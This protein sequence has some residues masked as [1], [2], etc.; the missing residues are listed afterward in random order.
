MRLELKFSV[1]C[2]IVVAGSCVAPSASVAQRSAFTRMPRSFALT[3]L[4]GV[5]PKLVARTKVRAISGSEAMARVA[6]AHARAANPRYWDRLR[7][8]KSKNTYGAMTAQPG[9][10]FGYGNFQIAITQG[11]KG[12]Q[13]LAIFPVDWM[14]P[15][16]SGKV[17][18]S[19]GLHATS[20]FMER[21]R[22]MAVVTKYGDHTGATLTRFRRLSD[23]RVA[24]RT[25]VIGSLPSL[26]HDIG[27]REAHT[28]IYNPA[29][30]AFSYKEQRAFSSTGD[31]RRSSRRVAGTIAKGLKPGLELSRALSAGYVEQ[32]IGR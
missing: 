9:S 23:G 29:T 25:L 19:V 5:T 11:R 28:S 31:P 17:E 30:G 26:G 13:R 15:T 27:I 10:V 16:G 22:G 21:K 24:A 2:A 6:Q 32:A 8:D 1:Y 18:V 12:S 14:A 7:Y 3:K 20:Y 4:Y